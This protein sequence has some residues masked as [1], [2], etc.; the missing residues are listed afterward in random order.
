L[1]Q[2]ALDHVAFVGRTEIGVEVGELCGRALVS[3]AL[4]LSGNNPLVLTRDGNLDAAVD[5]VRFSSFGVNQ[6]C[7]AIRAAI[8]PAEVHDEFLR[9]LDTVISSVPIGDPAEDV[10]YVPMFSER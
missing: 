1:G 10:L 3:S 9:K 2:H 5:A 8:V 6:G 7:T 4:L